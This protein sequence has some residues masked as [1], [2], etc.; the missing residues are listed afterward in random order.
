MIGDF[1]NVFLIDPLINLFVFLNVLVGNAGIAVIL[2]TIIIRAITFPLTMRQLRT[3][4]VMAAIPP[5][6]QDT[7]KRYKNPKRRSEEQ[8]KL[9]REMGV[10]PLGCFGSMLIQFP[11]LAALYATFRL[12]LGQAPEAVVSLSSRLYP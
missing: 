4:R 5:S 2:L 12:S 3:T 10:N 1:F 7:Q 6:I 8:M 11:I 9:Y